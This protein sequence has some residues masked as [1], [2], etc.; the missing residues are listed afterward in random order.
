MLF[1][2]GF[3]VVFA[4]LWAVLY[5][6]MPLLRHA[7]RGASRLLARSLRLQSLHARFAAYLP[8]AIVVIAGL[9][10]TAFAA[11]EFLDIAEQLHRQAGPVQTIDRRVHDGVVAHRSHGATDFFVTMTTLGGPPG[12][13]VILG[14]FAIVLLVVHR[15]RW[16]TY[17]A[18]TAAGGGL[19]DFELKQHFARAR[20]DVAEML[21][22]A[23][24]YSF[25][26]GHAM[27]STVAFGAL[28]YLAFRTTRDWKKQSAALAFSITFVLGV[29]TSRVYLGVHWLSDVGAGIIGGVCWVTSTTMA[30]EMLRRVRRL[31]VGRTSAR[32]DEARHD[33]EPG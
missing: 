26:S 3:I 7:T 17:L 10:V 13:A 32:H 24:G 27:E 21:R 6:L 33:D 22:H 11:D 28:T 2:I 4:L 30:Y 19:L 16:F 9:F 23:S 29:A 8:I 25:P 15:Y 14:G 18:V 31:R 5:P 12:V 20:P 1:F